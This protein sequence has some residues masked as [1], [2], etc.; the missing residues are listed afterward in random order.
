[1]TLN[2]DYAKWGARITYGVVFLVHGYAHVNK[3][4]E[5]DQ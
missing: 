1:M 2:N 5:A 3:V 4:Q